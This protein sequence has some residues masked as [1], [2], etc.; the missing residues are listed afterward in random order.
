MVAEHRGAYSV[1]TATGE[2]TAEIS[3]RMRYNALVRSEL[4][5]VGDWVALSRAS[6]QA[7]VTRRTVFARLDPDPRVGEQLLAANVDVAF[8]VTSLNHDFNL[9]RLERYLSMTW[10][11]GARPVIVSK[12]DL[13]PDAGDRAGGRHGRRRPG[14]RRRAAWPRSRRDPVARAARRDGDLSR[15]VRRR[16]VDP[17]Q[18]PGRQIAP[19]RRGRP[20]G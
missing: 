14:R 5:V 3:G 10:A 13:A 18:R 7:V 12:A 6:I 15:L 17:H 2:R 9:R 8:L 11:S 16:Q 4:P 20:A 19:G 1:A